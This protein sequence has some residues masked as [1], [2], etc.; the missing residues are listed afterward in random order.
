MTKVYLWNANDR[1]DECRERD[2]DYVTEIVNADYAPPIG[3]ILVGIV[4]VARRELAVEAL[5]VVKSVTRVTQGRRRVR[6]D[7]LLLVDAQSVDELMGKLDA[8][9]RGRVDRAGWPQELRPTKLPVTGAAGVI[10][11]LAEDD[12]IR[13]WLSSLEKK[14]PASTERLQEMQEARDA[15]G[16]ALDIADLPG[17]DKSVFSRSTR[18][19]VPEDVIASVVKNAH[20]AD[21]EED[22]IPEDLRRF[23][24]DTQTN[25]VT[26]HVAQF[27]GRDYELTVFNVNKK[28]FEVAL[29]VDLIYWDTINN[30]FTLVQ[31]KRLDPVQEN[32]GV[33]DWVYKNEAEIRRQLELMITPSSAVNSAADWRMTS[34]YWFK[35]VRRDAARFQDTKLLKGIYVPADYLRLALDDG[36]LRTGPQGGFRV[37]YNNVKRLTRA[38]FSELIRRG[39]IGTEATQSADLMSV[40]GDLGASGRSA[41]V[42]IKSQWQE[43]EPAEM[44]DGL[45][46]ILDTTPRDGEA[47]GLTNFEAMLDDPD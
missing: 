29:G 12:V 1:L 23:D 17:L 47:N 34:P 13:A 11:A 6:I 42:A 22:L 21:N 7:P 19:V 24:K 41:I 5:G 14:H 32:G 9:V 10:A 33:K 2:R 46:S 35:F 8:K 37:S 36:S 20:L 4:D 38:T 26:G 44:I 3:A 40:I 30:I 15:I 31:Y 27:R 25:L 43:S 16:L 18:D 39:L 28:P 45:D